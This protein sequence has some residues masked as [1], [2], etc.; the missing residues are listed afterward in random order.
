[1]AEIYEFAHNRGLAYGVLAVL[2]AV[3]AGW[4]A[5]LMFRRT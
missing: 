3:M 1:E 2:I 4:L 5:N